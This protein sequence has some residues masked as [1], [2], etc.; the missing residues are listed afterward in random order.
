MFCQIYLFRLKTYNDVLSIFF[1][2]IGT[3]DVTTLL[4]NSALYLKNLIF[5]ISTYRFRSKLLNSAYLSPL[6]CPAPPPPP[7]PPAWSPGPV[8]KNN[9]FVTKLIERNLHRILSRYKNNFYKD[10]RI[11]IV[12]L[13]W[14]FTPGPNRVTLFSFY[15]NQLFSFE[16]RVLILFLRIWASNVLILFLFSDLSFFFRQI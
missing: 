3:Q 7:P 6:S 10:V 16:A 14:P 15:K 4:L 5:R 1:H 8:P 9:C 2:R 13:F 12:G 11:G